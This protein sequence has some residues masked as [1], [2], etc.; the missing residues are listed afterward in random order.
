MSAAI[1]AQGAVR[2][3]LDAKRARLEARAAMIG[4]IRHHFTR[5]GFVE[6]DTPVLQ[7]VP[8]GEVHV[9]PF[10]TLL[11]EPFGQAERTLYL[12]TSPE[13]AMKALLAG[14]MER[15]FQFAHAYR[16]GERSVLH[17]PEFMMLEWYR[18]DAGWRAVAEDCRAIIM[19]ACGAAPDHLRGGGPVTWNG[20]TCDPGGTWEYLSFAEAF[21]R[22][23]GIDIL[24]T[25]SDARLLRTAAADAG[26]GLPDQGGWED[27][28]FHLLLDHIEPRLGTPAPTVLHDYPV[29]MACLAR[30]SPKD[31]RVAERF[32]IYMAGVE[33]ANG[34]GE[35][36][37]PDVQ[38]ARF[39]EDE[40]RRQ[41][42]YGRAMPIDETF[43][44]ALREMPE[45][46]GVALGFDRLAML[47]TGGTRIDDVLW[48]PIPDTLKRQSRSKR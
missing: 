25:G 48:A 12:H 46:A 4:A 35:L 3:A 45:A 36:N 19:A 11:E 26:L 44:A 42:L 27:L 20:R 9:R 2:R 8:G 22:Y 47:L 31:P 41:T 33:I 40:A 29:A 38:R 23:A 24:A 34:Y 28:V 18:A 16:N 37:D 7:P 10:A 15:I 21:S 1:S 17:H 43:L 32:E 30:V 5:Q 6:V 14:G 39:L 13:F